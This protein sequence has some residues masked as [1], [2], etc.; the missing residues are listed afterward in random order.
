MQV[1]LLKDVDTLGESGEVKTVRKGFARNHLLPNGLAVVATPGALKDLELRRGRI[2]AKAEKKH[3]EDQ[4]KAKKLEAIGTLNLSARAGEDGR[5]FG[6]VTT[7]LIATLLS[8]KTGLEIDRKNINLNRPINRL[9]EYELEV[10]FSPRV[11][12]TIPV[13]VSSEEAAGELADDFSEEDEY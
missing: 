9:G 12:S 4:G 10:R 6:A 11:K 7:R 13:L 3:Q 5:L 8:E 1:I 2:N